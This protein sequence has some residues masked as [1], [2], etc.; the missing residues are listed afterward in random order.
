MS[1]Y[2]VNNFASLYEQLSNEEQNMIIS[3][4][5]VCINKRQAKLNKRQDKAKK[6]IMDLAGCLKNKTKIKLTDEELGVSC[7]EL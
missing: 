3:L 4:M 6:S 5:E 2:T 7:I 1:S